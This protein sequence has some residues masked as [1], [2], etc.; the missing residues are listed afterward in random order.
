MDHLFSTGTDV[1]DLPA[2]A[3]PAPEDE[4]LPR[5]LYQRWADH[6]ANAIRANVLGPHERM[7]SV[8]EIRERH[9]VSH[10]T[11]L[12]VL[13]ELESRGL[14]EARARVGYF[15]RTQASAMP[16]A[17]EPQKLVPFDADSGS[18]QRI[19]ERIATYLNKARLVGEFKVDLG[20]AMPAP[21][22]FDASFLNRHAIAL[23]REQ[24]DL[25]VRAPSA[26]FTHPE[27]QAAM[28]RYALSFGLTIA[29]SGITATMGNSE[30]MNIS[31]DALT[32]PGDVVAIESPTFYGIVQAVQARGLRALE[33][34]S[35]PHTG[36]SPE[37]LELALRNYPEL[38]AVV[39]V[40]HLQMPLGATMPDSH[41]E[42]IVQMCSR[43]GVALIED[44]IYR[45]FMEDPGVHRPCRAWD[46]DGTVI[47]CASL[48]KSFAPG[49][50]LGWMNAGRW[51]ERV[52][53]VKFSR[54]RNMPMWPQLLGARTIGSPFHLRHLARLRQHLHR[55]R[56]Q[57]AQAVARHFPIGTRMS[58]PRGGLSIWV[59]LPPAVNT[60]RL[61]DEALALGIRIAPGDMFSSTDEY[62][63][64]L[65]LSCGLP[66]TPVVED[67]YRTLGRMMHAQLDH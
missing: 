33:I 55:Q 34:P 9:D 22:L 54:S 20:S 58:L 52:Q 25:L 26:P 40:P 38:K 29:P 60:A 31:L 39:V 7:P 14:I 65:R 50:R 61:Y 5:H 10:T 59:E 1:L 35:S 6:Y 53:M 44:D 4:R 56:E 2:H 66:F 63:H 13:R 21:E 51:H 57:A 64:F 49:L 16:A 67:A 45:E 37:A 30:A 42:R 46:S 27:F 36:M 28:S 62:G 43:H 8:R 18:F 24:P 23:L 41:K 17:R 47:Y 32:Q 11:A 48:S 19:G 15:V 3:T 12:Q